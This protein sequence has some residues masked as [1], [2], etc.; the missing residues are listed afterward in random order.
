[1]ILKEQDTKILETSPS[2]FG[3]EKVISSEEEI[4]PCTGELLVVQRLLQ[5][6]PLEIDQ[7]QI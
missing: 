5:S 7:S 6:Q 4:Q 3:E 1:M 2:S